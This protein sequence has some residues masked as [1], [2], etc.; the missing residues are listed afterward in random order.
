MCALKDLTSFSFWMSEVVR[1]KNR[2]VITT[3]AKRVI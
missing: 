3:Q 1:A 2:T